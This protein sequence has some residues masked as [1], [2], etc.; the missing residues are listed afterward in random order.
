MPT[1]WGCMPGCT[2][3]WFDSE[4]SVE[5]SEKASA[6]VG[7]FEVAVFFS[8]PESKATETHAG[9]HIVS[10]K[11]YARSESGSGTIRG[12]RSPEHDVVESHRRNVVTG[13][14]ELTHLAASCNG[15]GRLSHMLAFVTARSSAGA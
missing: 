15:T 2:F 5:I 10:N 8:I 6:L 13:A 11:V 3:P 12:G 9:S 7:P 14:D 1:E 4:F